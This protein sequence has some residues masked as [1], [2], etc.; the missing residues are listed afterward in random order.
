MTPLEG[1]RAV[2]FDVGG[3]LIDPWP[4]VGHVYAAAAAKAGLENYDPE[5]LNARFRRAWLAK[6]E[7]DYSKQAWAKLVIET[8]DGAEKAFGARSAFFE[9]LYSRFTEASAWRIYEDVV[10]ALEALRRRGLRL[11]VISNWDERL[12]PLLRNLGLDGFFDVIEVSAESGFHKPAP[13]IFHRAA[14]KLGVSAAAVLHIGDSGVEDV[15]GAQDAGLKSVL[16]SR[17]K[18]REGAI[19]SLAEVPKLIG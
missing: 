12:R 2:S 18:P 13:E 7:F 9:Q 16:L 4:S 3:T 17:F 1:V 5:H 15:T 19:S 6:R 11:A 14:D 8:F 10:P